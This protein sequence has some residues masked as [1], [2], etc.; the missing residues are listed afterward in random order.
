[1]DS[2][3]VTSIGAVQGSSGRLPHRA[4]QG[5]GNHMAPGTAMAANT[6]RP[7]WSSWHVF[8]LAHGRRPLWATGEQPRAS[9]PAGLTDDVVRDGR[10]PGCI[11]HN[12]TGLESN[13]EKR[14]IKSSGDNS[15]SF[16]EAHV[17]PLMCEHVSA[18]HVPVAHIEGRW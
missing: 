12:S 5:D 7:V 2:S 4:N 9:G 15:I 18:K 10:A 17:D 6:Q 16:G 11:F 13:G 14:I 8:S 3:Q 1:M